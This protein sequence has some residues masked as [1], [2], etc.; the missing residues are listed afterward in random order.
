MSQT[1]LQELSNSDIDWLMTVGKRRKVDADRFLIKAGQ[2]ISA[3]YWLIDG[4]LTISASQGGDNT[5]E[6]AFAALEEQPTLERDIGR[7]KKWRCC[8]RRTVDSN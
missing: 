8:W 5:L 7:I 4:S 2:Q 1:L 6:R 3:F